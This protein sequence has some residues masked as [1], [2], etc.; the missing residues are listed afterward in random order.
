LNAVQF[1]KLQ[2][3]QKDP[4][5][6]TE[7]AYI[8]DIFLQLKYDSLLAEFRLKFAWQETHWMMKKSNISSQGSI[9]DASAYYVNLKNLGAWR[10]ELSKNL[11]LIAF[12]TQI[13]EP[14][15]NFSKLSPSLPSKM[16][17]TLF[18][19]ITNISLNYGVSTRLTTKLRIT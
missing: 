6:Y 19:A 11:Q 2:K 5:A 12:T 15:N 18:L 17:K 4:N 1:F 16:K 13:S 7:D 9:N 8:C 14:K 3:D 10:V